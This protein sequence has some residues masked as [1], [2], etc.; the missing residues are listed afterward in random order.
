MQRTKRQK[1]KN[2]YNVQGKA[3]IEIRRNVSGETV[4]AAILEMVALIEF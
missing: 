3:S 1:G 4:F 2:I